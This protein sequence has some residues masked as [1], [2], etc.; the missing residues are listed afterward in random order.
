MLLPMLSELNDQELMSR[1]SDG[2]TLAFEELYSRHKGPV[3]RYLLRQSGNKANAEEVFQEVWIKVIRARD[4]YRPLAKFTTWL[5]Q[6]ARNCFIDFVRRQG[7]N[8]LN[9]SSEMEPDDIS[10]VTG[11]PESAATLSQ[12][13]QQLA[14]ALARLPEEQR[15]VFL[16]RAEGGLG[17]DE[18]AT[19]TA[20]GRETVKSRLRYAT[21]KLRA[22]LEEKS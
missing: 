5:Y 18:I 12:K 10:A 16:L 15:E 7:R 8:A 19:V 6:V 13:G 17:L 20:T 11:D 22:T 4:T 3:Y 14:A 1:Y 2:E 21:R 9:A